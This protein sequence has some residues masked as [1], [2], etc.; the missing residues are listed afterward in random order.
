MRL[1]IIFGDNLFPIKYF[2]KFKSFKFIT[3]EAKDLCLHFSYHKSRL[4]FLLSAQRNKRLEMLQNG[5]DVDQ[6]TLDH[7][8]DL[9]YVEKLSKYCEANNVLEIHCYEKEDKFFREMIQSFC[10]KK[11]IKL[12]IYP[13]PLFLNSHQDFNEYLKRHKKPFMKSFYEESRKRFNILMNKDGSPLGGRWSF[14]DENRSKLKKGIVVPTINS[15][16]IDS[17]S[18]EVIRLIETKF[19]N[20]PGP[21]L[22]TNP[23]LF[24]F[25]V[26]RKDSLNHLN[27]FLEIKLNSFGEFED[28]ISKH[29]DFIFHSLLSPLI[30]VG[31]LTPQEV[32]ETTLKYAQKNKPAINSLEGFVRQVLGWREFVR[33]IYNNYSEQYENKNFFKHKR[34]L[35][36]C[37]Y[38]GETGIDPLDHVIK[39]VNKYAYAHH[40][41]RLMILSNIML[42]LE[43]DP[44]E[45]HRFF[46]EYFIDSM[47]WV[48]GP[49]VYCMGQ[50]SD[51]G[52][53]ATKPYIC[54]S[55]YMRRMGGYPKGEW[56]D[57]VDGLYWR[58]IRKHDNFFLKNPR[59]SMMVSLIHKMDKNKLKIHLELAQK[60]KER[61]TYL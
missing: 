58:F 51:G 18:L 40:I 50:F 19:P 17:V 15:I 22:E 53:F 39:K 56:C 59:L 43:V 30:N 41:E 38:Q 4:V 8:F 48:M 13:S 47:D 44:I 28:A 5:F 52:I 9:S 21:N 14:D 10:N 24:I 6:I 7:S 25:P 35:K 32:I 26:T 23:E 57:A 20:N 31:L 49:N 27:H 34:K 42:L 60:V 16:L 29:E 37:F 3:I 61:I 36:E 55:N 2:E 33:G 12:V 54:G 45:V 46:N 11:K 1:F